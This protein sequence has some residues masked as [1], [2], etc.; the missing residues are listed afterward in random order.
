[1]R[2]FRVE[3]AETEAELVAHPGVAQAVVVARAGRGR[4]TGKHLVAYVVPATG[5]G[6]VPEPKELRA[7]VSARLPEFMVPSAV[8]VLERFPLAP[9][10]KLDR[11]ALPEPDYTGTTYRPPRTPRE[12]ILAALFAE[13]LGLDRVGVDDSFFELGG[14]SLL[15]TRLIARLRAELGVE[16]PIRKIFDMPTVAALAQWSQAPGSS[17][18]PRLRK[19]TVEE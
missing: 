2:G 13:V 1:M 6:P 8:V 7:F 15:A 16:L 3:P 12:E 4:S 5:E 14:H 17:S 18:R 11:A 10:G 9:N 19:M